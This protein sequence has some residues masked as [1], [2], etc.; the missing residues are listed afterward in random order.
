MLNLKRLSAFLLIATLG[1][2]TGCDGEKPSD[3]VDSAAAKPSASATAKPKPEPD[4]PEEKGIKILD[5]GKD[6]RTLLRYAPKPGQVERLRIASTTV[7]AEVK[8]DGDKKTLEKKGV[9]TGEFVVKMTFKKKNDAGD[10]LYDLEIDEVSVS[11]MDV[12]V[13]VMVATKS[14]LSQIE[15]VKG[16][17]VISDRGR[18]REAKFKLDDIK[19]D[20][21]AAAKGI[22]EVFGG[23]FMVLPT[24]RVG[25]GAKWEHTEKITQQGMEVDQVKVYE[26]VANKKGEPELSV[27]VKQT[28]KDTVAKLGKGI[29]MKILAFKADGTGTATLNL[30][31]IPVAKAKL[32]SKSETEMQ[33]GSRPKKTLASDATYVLEGGIY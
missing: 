15:G 32:N 13:K 27:T 26:L 17:L 31:H 28:A 14:L 8:K 9:P 4:K 1:V 16:T 3:T 22:E 11:G 33:L 21:A 29:E 12:P 30:S 18:A 6:P 10:L 19:P 5:K 24:A 23:L 7:H 25:V 2:T 20:A